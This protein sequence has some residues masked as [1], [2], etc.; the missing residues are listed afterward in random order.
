M[1]K[2]TVGWLWKKLEAL[3][4]AIEQ[5]KSQPE[6]EKAKLVALYKAAE[7]ALKQYGRVAARGQKRADAKAPLYAAGGAIVADDVTGAG[8]GDD[9]LLPLVAVG[10][11]VAHLSTP[12][13]AS[14]KEVF[15]AWDNV[16]AR[17]EAIAE[18]TLAHEA[19]DVAAERKPGCYCRCYLV[20]VG[21][22]TIGRRPNLSA[23]AKE[24]E[25]IKYNGYR[26]GGDVIWM[27]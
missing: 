22:Y 7:E 15:D 12:P 4:K 13:P 14:R 17:L 8:V 10:L 27:N 1:E 26:C 18:V 24:C 2:I 9:V 19:A 5:D 6:E 23:C 16:Q 20:G 3:R 25:R 11:L 21:P